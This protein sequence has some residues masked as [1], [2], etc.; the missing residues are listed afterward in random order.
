MKREDFIRTGAIAGGGL[1]VAADVVLSGRAALSAGSSALSPWLAITADNVVTIMSPQSEMGQGVMTSIPMLVAEE[2]DADWSKAK[3]VQSPTQAAFNHPFFGGMA[4][5]GSTSV[6]AFFLPARKVGATARAMLVAAAAQQWSVQPADCR[7]ENGTVIHDASGKKATYGSL[8]AAAAAMP[9]PS[10]VALKPHEKWK[11]I[12]KRTPRVDSL[13]KSTGK[14]T[15]GIDV[16]VPGMMFA[17]IRH[18][19]VYGGTVASSRFW[20][21]RCAASRCSR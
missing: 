17:A 13:A 6:R 2:L 11:L 7:T 19:P 20:N 4:T 16:R 5:G 14:A 21:P 8:A 18:S 15:F 10:D 1:I 12:G 9:P 3:I